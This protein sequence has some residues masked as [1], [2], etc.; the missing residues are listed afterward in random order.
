MQVMKLALKVFVKMFRRKFWLIYLSF[1]EK[2]EKDVNN[3]GNCVWCSVQ[4]FQSINQSDSR[5]ERVLQD[6]E[7][8]EDMMKLLVD[9]N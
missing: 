9:L 8:N 4:E 2:E 6:A 3:L 5:Q 7:N 1:K